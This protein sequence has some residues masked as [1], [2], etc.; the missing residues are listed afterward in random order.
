MRFIRSTRCPLFLLT[1]AGMG[2]AFAAELQDKP[3]YRAAQ[4]ALQDGLPTIA[5]IKAGRLMDE[6]PVQSMERQTLATLVVESWIRAKDG[7]AAMKVIKKEKIANESYW[8]A[9]ALFLMGD[10]EAAEKL[11][12]QR[13]NEDTAPSLERLLLAKISLKNGNTAQA[14][15]VIL[16]ILKSA[17]TAMVGRAQQISDELDALDGK[18]A[19]S[20][21]KELTQSQEATPLLLQAERLILLDQQKEAQDILRS[22]LAS[23]GG[24]ERAHHAAAVLLADSLLHERTAT[25]ATEVLV[26]FLDNTL[27]SEAWS[28][29]FNLLARCLESSEAGLPPPDATVRWISE[30]NTVQKAALTPLASTSTFQGHAMLLLSRWLVSQVRQ[31]EALGMLEAGFQLHEGHPQSDETMRLA[32]ETYSALKLDAR[33]SALT[34]QW[35][36]R[37]GSNGSSM[38]ESVSAGTAFKRGDYQQACELF[39]TAANLASTL[40]ERRSALYNAGASALRGG[41]MALYQSLLGQLQVASAEST[42]PSQDGS[43]D[44][45]LDSALELAAKGR[46]E[47]EA[48]LKRITEKQPP[49]PR[50]IEAWLALAELSI[51]RVPADFALAEKAFKTAQE[52]PNISEAQLQRAI[53]TRLWQL[54]RQGQL[55]SLTE[56]GAEFLTR[57]PTSVQAALVRMKVA[58]AFFRLENFASARTEFEL[59]AKNHPASSYADTALYFAGMSALSMMSDEGRNAAIMLWQEVAEKKGPLSI[60]ARQQQALAKRRAGQEA[61]ALKLMDTLLAE[62][63]LSEELQR[64]LVCEKAEILMLLGKEDVLQLTAAINLLQTALREDDLSYK[65]RA[66]IGYTLAVALN[67]SGRGLE[68]LEACYDVVKSTGFT[69]PT[70]PSEFRWFYRAGFFGIELIETQKQWEAAAR[71]AETLA[72][73][74][75]DRATEAKE[76]ATKI[77]LEHFL[78]DGK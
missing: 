8:H 5:A 23:K 35:R 29:A 42:L 48:E 27:E 71:L 14:R 68:A 60:P 22:I 33:V 38:V 7:V 10:L 13:V 18:A 20:G 19:G 24:G 72:Q 69:G 52:W 54:D 36:K 37:F 65:W 28:P 57:W 1:L 49:H 26:Q 45:D 50:A 32:L 75:G 6:T 53:T 51:L 76:R 34:D 44:L 12:T 47:A 17:D 58:D 30:G 3:D 25:K 70:D 74:K 64:S 2:A 21:P 31:L 15:A 41:E 43:I 62:K 46:P 40:A 77:R 16:P 55:K 59:V 73:S 63:N 78:W 61:D 4:Q 66:R 67:S 9:Q 39:Q 56:V 11:L